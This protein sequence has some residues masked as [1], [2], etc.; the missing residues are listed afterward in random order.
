MV[1]IIKTE[2]HGCHKHLMRQ[3]LYVQAISL[4]ML[5]GFWNTVSMLGVF[6]R[7]KTK[8][9]LRL[10]KTVILRNSTVLAKE[11]K[12]VR[13]AAFNVLNYDNSPLIGVKPDRGAK[14]RDRI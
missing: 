3:T 12:Q 2:H 1:I 11:T 13:V 5:K 8:L 10:S 4:K 6:N 9:C 7:F 14:H